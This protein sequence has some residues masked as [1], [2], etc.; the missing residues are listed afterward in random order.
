[1]DEELKVLGESQGRLGESY[2]VGHELDELD[3][4]LDESVE[5]CRR[6][7]ES[8]EWLNES[9]RVSQIV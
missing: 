1:M 8:V 4:Q 3:E 6:L 9:V 7:G 5:G 2:E